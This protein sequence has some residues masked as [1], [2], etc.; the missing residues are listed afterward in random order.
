VFDSSWA[1]AGPEENTN[2]DNAKSTMGRVRNILENICITPKITLLF[3]AL[4]LKGGWCENILFVKLR[5]L[6]T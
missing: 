3:S 5:K 1:V 2:V 6:L 4:F